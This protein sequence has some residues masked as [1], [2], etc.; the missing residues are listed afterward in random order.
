MQCNDKIFKEFILN[1]GDK[2]DKEG[3]AFKFDELVY[4]GLDV[5]YGNKTVGQILQ[6]ED[7][8]KNP[9]FY[10]YLLTL[11]MPDATLV[12]GDLYPNNMVDI[13][14][15]AWVERDEYVY[16]VVFKR[17]FYKDFYE[18]YFNTEYSAV[19]NNKVF[20][21]LTNVFSVGLQTVKDDVDMVDKFL[22][23]EEF[24]MLK[25][26]FIK[27]QLNEIKNEE[28]RKKV[29]QSFDIDLSFGYNI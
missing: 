16:D 21:K 13:T 1:I 8:S 25:K 20:K 9:Y 5:M 26:K 27:D 17:V 2:L 18:E 29:S 7:T 3:F 14:P 22:S 15:Y 12:K 4:E 28:V 6:E 10:S 19:F 11:S 24:K 23:C